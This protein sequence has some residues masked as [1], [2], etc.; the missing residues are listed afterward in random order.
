[1]ANNEIANALHA[2]GV[3]ELSNDPALI[4]TYGTWGIR[5]VFI[6]DV[7]LFN[8]WIVELEQPAM[9]QVNPS[10]PTA[11]ERV[12][13]VPSLT[14]YS[15][16]PTQDAPVSAAVMPTDVP[17]IPE[18]LRGHIAITYASEEEMAGQL[19]VSLLVVRIPGMEG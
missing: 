4:R 13:V 14:L 8:G 6:P 19:V 3:I 15:A 2:G 16:S 17:G 5:R 9:F 7:V 1:M 12:N 18:A 11:D 10:D